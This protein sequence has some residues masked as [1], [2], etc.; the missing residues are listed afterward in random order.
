[1]LV[2]APEQSDYVGEEEKRSA[3]EFYRGW[4]GQAEQC[5]GVNE[6]EYTLENLSYSYVTDLED[7][8][9]CIIKSGRSE[10]IE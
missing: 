4:L 8:L 5:Y 7:Y 3:A 6:I 2:V 10:N 1:M 9:Q